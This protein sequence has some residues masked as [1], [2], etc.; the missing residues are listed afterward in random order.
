MADPD[1]FRLRLKVLSDSY[2]MQLPQKLEQ[3]ELAWGELPIVV[4]DEEAFQALH[5]MVHS[6]S[7]SGKTFGFAMLSVAA[8]NLEDALQPLAQA[9]A[10]PDAAQRRSIRTLLDELHR[11]LAQSD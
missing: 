5:R 10:M 11:T 3:I 8:R 9:Q 6:L 1:D 4:W 7:G 2:A